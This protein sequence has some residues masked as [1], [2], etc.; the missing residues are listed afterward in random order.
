MWNRSSNFSRFIENFSIIKRLYEEENK[1]IRF[2]ARWLRMSITYLQLWLDRYFRSIH[3]QKEIETIINIKKQRIDIIK[4][5][6]KQF[7]MNNKGRWIVVNQIVDY[8]NNHSFNKQHNDTTYYEVYSV[9]KKELN[10]SW[11]KASQRPHRWFQE[12]LEEARNIFKQFILQ[13]KE[14]E[15]IIVWID[16]SSFNSAVLT[17][18]SWMLKWKDPDRIIRNSSERFTEKAFV[19]TP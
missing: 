1:D 7:M 18:Y 19:V 5:K 3:K 12:S 16:E 14:R 6:I 2:I 11:R 9:L 8:I 4:D 17:I 15:F 10:F 13:L